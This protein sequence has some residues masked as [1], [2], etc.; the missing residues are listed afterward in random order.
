MLSIDHMSAADYSPSMDDILRSR[1]QTMG[2]ASHEFMVQI[3]SKSVIWHLYD[4]G[5]ACGQ[6][7]MWVP[8]FD[9]TNA[10]IL[11]APISAFDQVLYTASL[12]LHLS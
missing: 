3:S 6:W 10:I 7:H 1:L 11:L 12:S 5:G 8:Y 2:I 4:V 9:D